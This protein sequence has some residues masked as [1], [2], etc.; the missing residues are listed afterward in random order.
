MSDKKPFNQAEFDAG[1]NERLE[2]LINAV[3]PKNPTT[4]KVLYGAAIGAAAVG[5]FAGYF[6]LIAAAG[7]SVILAV[8]AKS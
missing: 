6:I 2:Y 5:I 1:C 7:V 4:K 3:K 8:A